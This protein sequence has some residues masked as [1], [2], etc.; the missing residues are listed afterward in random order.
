MTS[1]KRPFGLA[2]SR[3]RFGGVSPK[4]LI[5]YRN[6]AASSPSAI[7]AGDPVARGVDATIQPATA[8][9]DYWI[10]IAR[11]FQYVDPTTKRP[12]WAS[13]IAANTSSFDGNLYVDVEP[14]EGSTFIIQADATVSHGDVGDANYTV[15][16]VGTGDA[17]IGIS[18][19]VLRVAGRTTATAPLRIQKIM[20]YPDN[21]SGDAFTIVEVLVVQTHGARV[22]AS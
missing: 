5:R 7:F 8:T 18:N 22:S 12:T 20:P 6:V 15:S 4:G 19:A 16:G 2:G 9:T 17:D 3:N 21:A 11:G 10:G 13:F 14:V 1:T